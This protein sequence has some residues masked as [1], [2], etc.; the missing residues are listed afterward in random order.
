[1]M[2][3]NFTK[4][5]E[6]WL[7]VIPVLRGHGYQFGYKMGA[8]VIGLALDPVTSRDNFVLSMIEKINADLRRYS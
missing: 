7:L 5:N 6:F 4:I 3:N 1:M 2:F 8:E